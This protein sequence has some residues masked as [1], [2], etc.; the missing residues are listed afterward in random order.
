MD[1]SGEILKKTELIYLILIGDKCCI[2]NK[3]LNNNDI[4]K[5]NFEQV[6]QSNIFNNLSIEDLASMC[7]KS[8]T[9]FKKEFKQYFHESPHKWFIN[10]R[11]VHTRLLLIS[12]NK[13]ISEISNECN[14]TNTSHFIKLFKRKY[15]VT[16]SNFRAQNKNSNI[17]QEHMIAEDYI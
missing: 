11:L 16:P 17:I 9:T 2:K 15:L 5:V 12:T 4:Y 7:N 13:S 8:L 14:F 1:C 6:I 3:I 10:E